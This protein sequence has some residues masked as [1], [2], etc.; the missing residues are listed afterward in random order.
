MRGA[1]TS[2]PCALAS[3]SF[4]STLLM[5]GATSPKLAAQAAIMISIHA[6]H[7]RS[8]QASAYHGRRI[9]YFNPRSSCE[10]RRHMLTWYDARD[11]SIHAP[12]ARSDLSILTSHLAHD[13]FQSTLLMR[14]ATN[15]AKSAGGHRLFQSTLLMRGATS[16]RPFAYQSFVISIHA[17]HARSDLLN[18]AHLALLFL[19]QSTLLMRGATTQSDFP[20]CRV[21]IS[22]HAPHARSDTS[23]A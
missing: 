6:P 8:D 19:F 14:G 5:R 17:P 4:Q 21:P 3:L 9:P 10:E 1:T 11:I 7:A 12:H 20:G 13:I 2:R 23:A 18:D 22:I 16:R 15:T